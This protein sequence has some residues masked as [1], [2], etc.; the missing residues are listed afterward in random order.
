MSTDDFSVFGGSLSL[1]YIVSNRHCT[2]AP[3]RR[4]LIFHLHCRRGP[5]RVPPGAAGVF[6]L[7]ESLN[8]NRH[9][10]NLNP[11]TLHHKARRRFSKAKAAF[12]S[13]R[14][15]EAFLL[16]FSRSPL[17]NFA[18]SAKSVSQSLSQFSAAADGALSVL[19]E[20]LAMSAAPQ[21][22]F[23]GGGGK[24]DGVDAASLLPS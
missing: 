24:G 14:P 16:S 12:C 18:S 5:Q 17:R 10:L 6:T 3:S 13:R 23:Y 2:K 21:S 9:F 4:N 19:S 20:I 8:S 22:I 7:L 15:F 11:T 1:I